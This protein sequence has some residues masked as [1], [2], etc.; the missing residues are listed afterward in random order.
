MN[1]DNSLV[2]RKDKIRFARQ[3]RIM[4]TISES[5]RVEGTPQCKLRLR[6]FA[7]DAG[8][9]AGTSLLV[10]DIGHL[11]PSSAHQYERNGIGL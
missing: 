11:H 9:H 8:H 6:I 10:Y 4:K 3:H 7:T 5:I 1:E 2:H